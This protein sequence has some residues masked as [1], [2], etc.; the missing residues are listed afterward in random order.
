M[1]LDLFLPLAFLLTSMKVLFDL[2][3]HSELVAFQM[4]GLS[5][6]K[7]LRPFF[8]FASLLSLICYINNQWLAPD[9]QN[10]AH[11]FRDAAKNKKKKKE[12]L[13]TL[14]LTDGTE[15]VYQQFDPAKKEFFDVFWI[16]TSND[17]WHIKYLDIGSNP[18]TGHFTDHLTRNHQHQFEKTESFQYQEFPHLS[19]DDQTVIREFVPFEHRSLSTLFQ[20]ARSDTAN[21]QSVFAHLHYKLALPLLPFLVLLTISPVTMQFSRTRPVFLIIAISL[22]GFISLRTILDGMLI[23][24]ENQ[25]LPAAVAI[26]SPLLLGLIL[27][28]RSFI[29]L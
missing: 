10:A 20:Q 29:K 19:W 7:L 9:A 2:N 6:K 26:W 11:A 5:K 1:H 13:F 22:L 3:A 25:V 12:H 23:L 4:A 14:P 18:P 15:L 21:Q 28:L 17:I 27:S 8:L 24:G 16:Q